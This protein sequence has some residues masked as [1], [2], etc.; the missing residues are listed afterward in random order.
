M[1]VKVV[2]LGSL[3]HEV[4]RRGTRFE[5]H[6]GPLGERLGLARLDVSALV[7]PP[8]RA[9]GPC[10]FHLVAESMVHVLGG[11]ARLRL[12]GVE[13][14]LSAGDVAALPP[15]GS[16]AHQL[17][18]RS[19]RPAH[20][21]FATTREVR[22][23]VGL[24]DS[25]KRIYRMRAGAGEVEDLV[26]RDDRV[27]DLWDGE[28]VD[29]PLGGGPPPAAE[30]DPRIAA[31]EDVEWEAFG[32]AVFHGLRKR[33]ARAVGAERLGYS[34]YRLEP[35][36]RPFPFHFHHANEEL[37]LL[38]SG[39]LQLRTLEGTVDLKPGDAFGCPPG[40][41]GA[42]GLL[43]AHDAPAEYFALST[44]IDPEVVEYPDSN[45]VYVMVGAPPGGDP[46]RREVNRIFRRAD[47][48]EYE[49]G[50]R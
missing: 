31:L 34:L 9:D 7:L 10:R 30:R 28:P 15:R 24:P 37:F 33:L 48:V 44:M 13:H 3:T 22:D 43:N 41:E 8:G 2:N 20:L 19:D 5:V 35:G 18:N 16:S 14:A 49:E 42:H 6:R 38:R 25:G 1:P 46:N 45:K 17:V 39:Y 27:V 26:L 36:E 50:E 32:G 11:E 29:E 21:L 40:T 12:G 23:V 47:A 4:E